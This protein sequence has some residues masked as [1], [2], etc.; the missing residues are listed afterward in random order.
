MST[1][2]LF[3]LMKHNGA[4]RNGTERNGFG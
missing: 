1:K 4:E 3:E 2:A